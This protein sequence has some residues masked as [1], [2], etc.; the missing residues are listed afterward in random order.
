V[1]AVQAHAEDYR[2]LTAKFHYAIRVA[3]LVADPVSDQVS[4]KFV[5][6]CDQL[7]TF[8]GVESRSQ[9]GSSYLDMWR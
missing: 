1:A 2:P 8:F 3:D 5:A 9:T 6:V 4:D 7:A